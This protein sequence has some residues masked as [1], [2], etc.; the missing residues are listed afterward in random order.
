MDLVKIDD[1]GSDNVCQFLTQLINHR[2]E[3][4]LFNYETAF[5]ADNINIIGAAGDR[6]DV[7]K[8]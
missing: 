1:Y 3:K 5:H 6:V 4:K 8:R 7:S 2:E